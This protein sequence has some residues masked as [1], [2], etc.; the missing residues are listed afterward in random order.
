MV[1]GWCSGRGGGIQEVS[2]EKLC[3]CMREVKSSELNPPPPSFF[4]GLITGGSCY[5]CCKTTCDHSDKAK[6]QNSESLPTGGLA[7]H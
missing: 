4:W 5:Y 3:P 2:N 7:F 6:Q 1:S